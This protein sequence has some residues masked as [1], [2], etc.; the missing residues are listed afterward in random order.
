M[1]AHDERRRGR[2]PGR[3]NDA[4]LRVRNFCRA[5]CEDPLYQRDIIDRARTGRLG[6]MEA[7][8][9][10]YG[11]G[12][13]RE[14]VDLNVGRQEQEDLSSLSAEELLGRLHALKMRLEEAQELE[15]QLAALNPPPALQ[16][17]EGGKE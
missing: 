9:W 12:R 2:P 17:L 7:V 14:T 1:P 8:I 13:P 4:T 15:A 3:V 16:L 6:S 5:V 11:Y 10:A